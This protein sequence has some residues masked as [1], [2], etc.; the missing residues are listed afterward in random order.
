MEHY[1]TTEKNI[2]ILISLLKAH[3]VKRVV[4]SPGATNITF[5]ASIQR[6]QYFNIY[7]CVDE[8]SAAYMACGIAM[9]SGEP[10]V[11]SCTGATASRNYIPGLT[12]AYYSKLPI[13]AVTSTQDIS[14]IGQLIP[15]VIDRRQPLKDIV[16][17]TEH[18]NVVSDAT[19]EYDATLKINRAILEL[20]HRGNGPVH[21]NMTTTYSR[22]YSVVELPKAQVI[23]RLT[24]ESV[25]PE[26]QNGTRVALF[27]GSHLPFSKRLTESVDKFCAH[28]DAV[29]FCDHS[30]GYKGKYRV[31]FAVVNAQEQ[32][33]SNMINLDLLIHIGEVS[34]D[35]PGMRLSAKQTWRVSED[36]ELRD[37]FHSLSIVFEMS[38]VLFFERFVCNAEIKRTAFLEE[39]L[40]EINMIRNNIPELPFSNTWIAQQTAHRIPENSV[41][42]LGILNSLRNWNYFDF[43]ESV[44]GQSNTGGFGIDGCMSTSVGA[45]C[46]NSGKLHFLIIGDLSFFYDMNILGNRHIGN[47]IRILLIN[48]GKGTEFRN[49]THPG[50]AFGDDADKY[51]AAGGHFGNQSKM[52]VRHFAED[53]GLS[54]FFADNKE[55]YLEKMP[56]FLSPQKLEKSLLFEVFTNNE[57]ESDAL[58]LVANVLKKKDDSVVKGEDITFKSIVKKVIGEKGVEIVRILKK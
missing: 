53:L 18:I 40:A 22:D 16:K 55:S 19:T 3:G 27:V 39:C 35:Y 13:L 9:E 50:Y 28:Y 51:I 34:G 21:L 42:H 44:T 31:Q 20:T 10:V 36:G 38:E 41:V 1:Y 7:S 33:R 24:P 58:K 54:Y 32:V 23:K 11:L 12:E 8:R 29:V 47:N 57:D 48:N 30:S 14:R 37:T 25:F 26:I 15:Q 2:Q 5:V 46:V 49:Y 45:S 17:L 43:P 6:D 56:I 52:L 4:V